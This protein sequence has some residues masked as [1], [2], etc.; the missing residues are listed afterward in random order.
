MASNNIEFL[1]FGSSIPGGYWGCCAADIIQ[2]FGCDPDDPAS[3]Q[4]VNGDEGYPIQDV[5]GND[6]FLG[7]T[8]LDVF[9]GRLRIGTFGEGDMPNHAFFAILTADQIETTNGKKWLRILK[10]HGFE[11]V[12]AVSNSVYS[13]S[14]LF[15]VFRGDEDCNINYIFGLFRNIGAGRV[16]NPYKPPEEWTEIES[17]I[18]VEVSSYAV[19]SGSQIARENEEFHTKVWETNGKPTF[20]TEKELDSE[21]VPVTYAGIRS[22]YPQESREKRQAKDGPDYDTDASPW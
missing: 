22:K 5:E 2:C 20:Y 14:S 7:K 9:K 21:G 17:G 11:F 13:G 15:G 12:R 16:R 4:L 3:I 19:A 6:L 18:P 10:E 1:R 8:N